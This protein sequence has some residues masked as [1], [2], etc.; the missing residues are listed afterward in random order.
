MANSPLIE[1]LRKKDKIKVLFVCLGNICRSPAAEG[2]FRDIVE[3][4]GLADRFEIDSAG[5]YSGHA[6]SL[7]DQRMRIHAFQR[8]YNLTHRARPVKTG[9]FHDFDLILSMDDSNYSRLRAFA[10]T[11]ETELK[12]V[13]TTDFCRRHPG[14]DHVPDPYYEGA[15]GFEIVLDLLEDACEGL[16]DSLSPAN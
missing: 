3:R 8:G 2:I 11:D 13:R 9:D 7:P 4:R 5:L 12:V 10:P 14:A 1:K 15:E 16:A 6:G